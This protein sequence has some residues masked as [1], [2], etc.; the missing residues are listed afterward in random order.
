M[1][2]RLLWFLGLVYFLSPYDAL[3]DVIIGWG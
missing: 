3:P 2:K 1:L